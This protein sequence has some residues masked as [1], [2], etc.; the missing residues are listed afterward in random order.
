MG[1]WFLSSAIAHQA[2]KFIAGESVAAP[3][4]TPQET[5]ELSLSVFNNVGLFAVGSGVFLLIL[6]PIIKKLMHGV[7]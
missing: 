1:F 5:L 7:K 2:G 6:S 4:A 3:D